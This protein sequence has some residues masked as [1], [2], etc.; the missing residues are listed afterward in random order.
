MKPTHSA[1]RWESTA[2]PLEKLP[3]PAEAE[4][5]LF[6]QRLAQAFCRERLIFRQFGFCTRKTCRCSTEFGYYTPV[7]EQ[8]PTR[9]ANNTDSIKL[10]KMLFK[11]SAFYWPLHP[12]RGFGSEGS[13]P[14]TTPSAAVLLSMRTGKPG[15]Y[16]LHPED[17]G[18]GKINQQNTHIRTTRAALDLAS[19]SFST[20]IYYTK[21]TYLVKTL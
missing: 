13:M 8:S 12:V 19:L 1:M 21:V 3:V 9:P 11:S 16:V 6:F 2:K 14:L 10:C 7:T 5:Q 20:I 18:E 15:V 4:F 17:S